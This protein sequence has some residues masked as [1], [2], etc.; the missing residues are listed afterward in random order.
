MDAIPSDRKEFETVVSTRHHCFFDNV[1]T[2]NKWLMDAL[3]E[4]A[5]GIQVTRRVLYTTNDATTYRVQCHLGLTCREQWFARTDV[6]TRL[7]VLETERRD[8][9]LNPTTI[10]DRI[11]RNRDALWHEV[12]ADLNTIVHQFQWYAPPEQQLRMAGFADFVELAC[13]AL[14]LP[15]ARLLDL[16]LGNQH[17]SALDNSPVWV[18]LDLWLRE[19][20]VSTKRLK[21]NGEWINTVRLHQEL[22]RVSDR[23]GQAADYDKKVPNPRSLSHQL[24]ELLPDIE[25][26]CDVEFQRRD[27]ANRYRFTL[28]PEVIVSLEAA[29]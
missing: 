24:R 10:F 14:H 15:A 5:T 8:K 27:T 3:A 9:K 26:K 22:R 6:A 1:D 21:N 16:I 20:D 23:A 11:R 29:D 7:V 17:E 28:K 13:A 2:P 25:T 12:L 18:N 4:V 19:E